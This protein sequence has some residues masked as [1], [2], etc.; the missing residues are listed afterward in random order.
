MPMLDL[1][2]QTFGSLKAISVDHKSDQ[3]AY[4]LCRCK[5]GKEKVVRSHDLRANP[6]ISCGCDRNARRSATARG[7]KASDGIRKTCSR[8][9]KRKLIR[10]FWVERSR[11][12]GRRNLCI[13]CEKIVGEHLDA[14]RKSKGLPKRSTAFAR[15][16][17]LKV[18]FHYSNGE[19]KCD[20]CDED[21]IEFLTIDHVNGGG[22]KHRIKIGFGNLYRWLIRNKFP[23]GY[24]V[25]C[26]NCN[27]SYGKYGYCPHRTKGKHICKSSS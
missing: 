2:G 21:L 17:R 5:C 16:S 18:L 24:R 11:F 8:C 4:W 14:V 22:T 19:M 26:M 25:L 15:E 7:L 27:F 10:E 23:E 9:R 3:G 12:D 13:E 1:T 6:E 20:C